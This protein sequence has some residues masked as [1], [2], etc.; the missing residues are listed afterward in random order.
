M[1]FM[2]GANHG[3]KYKLHKMLGSGT[4]LYFRKNTQFI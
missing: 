2:F 1:G 4:L 3:I